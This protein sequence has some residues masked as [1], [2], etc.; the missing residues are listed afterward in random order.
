MDAGAAD[1]IVKPFSP[2]E[3]VARVQGALRRTG[4]TPGPFRLGELTIDD[5]ER[6]VSVAGSPV[7]STA[8]EYDWIHGVFGR[9]SA[10]W[11]LRVVVGDSVESFFLMATHQK[12]DRSPPALWKREEYRRIAWK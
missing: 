11:P 10:G 4:E 12:E 3:L 8:T 5:E 1:Y 7:Q 9:D 6:R 2:T